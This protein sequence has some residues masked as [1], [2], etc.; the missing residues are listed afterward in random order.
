MN[1]VIC[2][3]LGILVHSDADWA[4]EQSDGRST[5]GF[6][7]Y[8]SKD[9]SLISWKSK[10]EP[11]FALSTWEAEDKGL[12]KTIQES[13]YLIQ[14]LDGIDAQ[15]WDQTAKILSNN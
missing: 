10:N 9:S 7:F 1:C 3:K 8:F 4:S 12:A 6:H 5:I 14:V 11:N 13:L 2:E 15:H